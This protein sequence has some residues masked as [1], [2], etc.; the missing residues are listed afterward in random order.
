[1]IIKNIE[2]QF[3]KL[4]KMIK[5]LNELYKLSKGVINIKPIGIYILNPA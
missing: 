4:D 5:Q 1:M 3:I 2:N